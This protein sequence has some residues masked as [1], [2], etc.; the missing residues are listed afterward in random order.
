MS[1]DRPKD[2]RGEKRVLA[3]VRHPVGGV[4]THILYTYPFLA[5]RGYQF[6][7]VVP[8][9]ETSR[10]FRREVESWEGTEVFCAPVSGRRQKKPR[11]VGVTR[12]LLRQ[13]R[14]SLIHSHGLGATVQV[15]FANLGFG[16]P[17]IATS[18]DAFHQEYLPGVLGRAKLAC[19]GTVLARVDKMVTVS[20]DARRNHLEHL[21]FQRQRERRIAVIRNGIDVERFRDG[22]R[23]SPGELRQR[24]ALS[25][26]VFLI[27]F[28]GRFMPV[29]GF[30]VL[31]GALEHLLRESSQQ[32]FH[33][34]AVG[35]DDCLRNYQAD[36]KRRG[37]FAR[38]ITFLPYVPDVNP[39][40]RQLDL[41]VMPS[42]QEACGLL[43]MEAMVAGVPV[44][45]TDCTGLREVLRGS[46]SVT[47]PPNDSRA[48]A[49]AI[50]DA[51]DNPW[52][53]EAASYA[54]TAKQRFDVT[55]T[56]KKLLSL[57]EQLRA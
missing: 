6:T 5:R 14:F 51:I 35:S 47:V 45:G 21:P 22:D 55:H 29:K 15:V 48:L 19:L 23:H 16:V 49:E 53:E 4:H 24:L 38:H 3:V 52:K 25:D 50:R 1:R 17:H 36:V 43:A 28:L 41:L 39:L 8:A 42:L 13:R 32:P 54:P 37:D 33:L 20:H 40:L 34:V 10:P 18:H 2:R 27:G 44:L 12:R 31:V 57:F 30:H 7:F 46:P 26:R 56:A 11:F 9:L